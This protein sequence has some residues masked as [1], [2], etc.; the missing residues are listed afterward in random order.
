[1]DNIRQLKGCNGLAAA[2]ASGQTLRDAARTAGL[3]ERT[4]ARRMADPAFRSEVA[5]IRARILEQ[6]TGQLAA[7]ATKAVTTLCALLDDDLANVRLRAACAILELSHKLY[8][9]RM[10]EQRLADLEKRIPDGN[11]PRAIM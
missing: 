5:A 4:A 2:L 10:M 8:D 3:S 1:M 7:A 6:A 11:G 9:E